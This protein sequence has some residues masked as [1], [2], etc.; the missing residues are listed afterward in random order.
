MGIPL[1]LWMHDAIGDYA[2]AIDLDAMDRQLGVHR[3]ARTRSGE[4]ARAHGK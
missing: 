3:M 4:N 1:S 2:G